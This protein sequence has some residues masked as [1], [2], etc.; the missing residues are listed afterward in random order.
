MQDPR[1]IAPYFSPIPLQIDG[2]TP[3]I[4]KWQDPA[5]RGAYPIQ[6]HTGNIGLVIGGGHIVVDIDPRNGGGE[7]FIQ[8]KNDFPLFGMLFTASVL[9]ARGGAHFY[10]RLPEGHGRKVKKELEQY[11]GID[12]LS[13]S[14]YVVAPG[15]HMSSRGTWSWYKGP[16]T[17]PPEFPLD[18]LESLFPV[19]APAS[20]DLPAPDGLWGV[21]TERDLTALL[22]ALDVTDFAEHDKW[23]ELMLACHHATAGD[24]KEVFLEWSSYDSAYADDYNVSAYRWDS[25]TDKGPSDRPITA[26]SLVRHFEKGK[27]PEWLLK[28]LDYQDPNSLFKALEP[29]KVEDVAKTIEEC[30]EAHKV[31]IYTHR[32][33]P[34][35]LELKVWPAIASDSQLTAV[36]RRQLGNELAKKL[37]V[38]YST[39]NK[40]VEKAPED[41]TA[42]QADEDE[43][44][45]SVA[46]G[47][48]VAMGGTSNVLYQAGDFWSYNDRHW[49]IIPGEN[50]KHTINVTTQNMGAGGH[51]TGPFINSVGSVL[52]SLHPHKPQGFWNPEDDRVRVNVA[53]SMLELNRD[54]QWQRIDHDKSH[55]MNYVLPVVPTPGGTPVFDRYMLDAV[56][57]D[58]GTIRTLLAAM[59]YTVTSKR[60]WW[61]KCF[62][63]HGDTDSGKSVYLAL[64]EALI[65][66]DQRDSMAMSDVGKE[67]SLA[68]LRGK[69]MNASGELNS[70]RINS[71]M[72]KK[73]IS[74]D[75]IKANRKNRSYVKFNNNAI[76]WFAGNN[77][78]NLRDG[79]SASLNRITLIEFPNS[80]PAERQDTDLIDKLVVELP[81]ILHKAL[82]IFAEEYTKDKGMSIRNT[83]LTSQEAFET[84]KATSQPIHRW[85]RDCMIP[86]D[87]DAFLSSDVVYQSYS[88]WAKQ[89]NHYQMSSSS[90]YPQLA[91]LSGKK[92]E[93]R[94][95][96]RGYPGYSLSSPF[97][98]I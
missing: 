23:L 38:P 83:P 32:A 65:P 20:N 29:E 72:F 97:N 68:D 63:L 80:I 70:T 24:G 41:K 94:S 18:I 16:V 95:G 25:M 90:F 73:L 9:T 66:A 15:A 34:L 1:S 22:G 78:P 36:T 33:D 54:G 86:A 58:E 2:N 93:R 14:R 35:K 91:K 88:E 19:D 27:A 51:L 37:G 44:Q 76:F 8:F 60:Q 11:K 28:R 69:L 92:S 48:L 74:G 79:S 49:E 57:G 17:A 59:V 75:S 30:F 77:W 98:K 39:L 50:V 26:R 61:K 31:A 67:Y 5:A 84:F 4:A 21:L 42:G 87:E 13:G 52:D 71:E 12:F 64:M 10:F 45:L 43:I 89:N 82:V 96:A 62:F 6:D 53:D 40:S 47:A 85:F 56:G 81:Q 55:R 46:Q 3:T 7:S